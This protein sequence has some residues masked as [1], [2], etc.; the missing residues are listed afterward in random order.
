MRE[1]QSILKL[2]GIS[3]SKPKGD[4]VIAVSIKGVHIVAMICPEC[5][6]HEFVYASEVTEFNKIKAFEFSVEGFSSQ[7]L[8]QISKFKQ[9]VSKSAELVEYLSKKWVGKDFRDYAEEEINI[10]C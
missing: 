7:D 8:S 4:W 3:F 5:D 6:D 1:I 9:A 2:S 10:E